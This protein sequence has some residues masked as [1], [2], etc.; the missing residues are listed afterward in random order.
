MKRLPILL[1]FLIALTGP[2]HAGE[3]PSTPTTRPRYELIKGKGVEV[4]E[5]YKKNLNAFNDTEPMV[6]ERKI[7]PELKD[8]EKPVWQEV[9]ARGKD[10]ELLRR[11]LRY[12]AVDRN[13]FQASLYKEPDLGNLIERY[14]GREGGE[15]PLLSRTRV[16]IDNDGNVED[17]AIL[18]YGSCPDTSVAHFETNL[19]VLKQGP[20]PEEMMIADDHPAE[21][22]LRQKVSP[23]LGHFTIADLFRYKG[24]TYVDKYCMLIK[25]SPVGC[26][27]KDILMVFKIEKNNVNE[28]C[29]YK[30]HNK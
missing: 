8:F 23:Q 15:N 30:Y 26:D 22:L 4:C 18:R 20:R 27:D 5:A 10:R 21:K 13:Q 28:I 1:Y 11:V 17:V 24:K 3:A 2:A 25:G 9:D 12:Q 14:K 19:F 7:D 6:C 16:D 29:R